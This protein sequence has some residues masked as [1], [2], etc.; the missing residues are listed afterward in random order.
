MV[1]VKS[2]ILL[3]THIYLSCSILC[4]I[5]TTNVIILVYKLLIGSDQEII[6]ADIL[7]NE[8]KLQTDLNQL[9]S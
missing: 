2:S 5:Y 3:I 7:N 6:N 9:S 1:K 4:N 8:I